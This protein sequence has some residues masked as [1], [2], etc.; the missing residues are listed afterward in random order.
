MGGVYIG[1]YAPSSESESGGGGGAFSRYH[2]WQK[3]DKKFLSLHGRR[4]EV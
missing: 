1:K 4:I 3:S 2:F